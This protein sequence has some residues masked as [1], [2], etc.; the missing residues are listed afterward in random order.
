MITTTDCGPGV[1]PDVV[2]RL[3]EPFFR[4]NLRAAE[5]LAAS[6]WVWLLCKPAYN[7]AMANSYQ[8]SIAKRTG[9]DNQA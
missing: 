8:K 3:G 9:S 4:P 5:P 6:G 2:N 7:L 1:P